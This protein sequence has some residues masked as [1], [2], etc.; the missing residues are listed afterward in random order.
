M[1]GFSVFCFNYVTQ[2]VSVLNSNVSDA[3]ICV[4]RRNGRSH[5]A[6][7]AAEA[8]LQRCLALCLLKSVLVTQFA[9]VSFRV[10]LLNDRSKLIF[11]FVSFVALG[12]FD[13]ESDTVSL[14]SWLSHNKRFSSEIRWMNPVDTWVIVVTW[15]CCGSE[16]HTLKGKK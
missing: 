1:L 14:A 16:R 12:C 5:I 2:M 9:V 13:V 7:L 10:L 15:P 6:R 4:F 8:A 3:V 11:H